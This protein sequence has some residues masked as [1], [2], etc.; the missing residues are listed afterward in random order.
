MDRRGGRI[1]VDLICLLSESHQRSSHLEDVF[2]A[3][4]GVAG[5]RA[6]DNGRETFGNV[7]LARLD[8]HRLFEEDGLDLADVVGR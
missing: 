6:V 7:R 5:E 4:V 1:D 2:E 8:R 3:S